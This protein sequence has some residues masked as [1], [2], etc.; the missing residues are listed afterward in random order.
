MIGEVFPS[1]SAF[2]FV[3]LIMFDESATSIVSGIYFYKLFLHL[4]SHNKDARFKGLLW[5][6]DAS[7]GVRR[8]GRRRA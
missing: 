8:A 5:P 2:P 6:P 7:V 1:L 4:G 3:D